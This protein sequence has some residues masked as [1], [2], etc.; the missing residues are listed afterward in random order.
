MT[1]LR[2]G[3]LP[4][5]V[6]LLAACGT[7]EIMEQTVLPTTSVTI[8]TDS[9]ELFMEHPALVVDEAARF[10]VHLTD[11]TDFRPLETGRVTL[12]LLPR[13]PGEPLEVVQDGPRAPGIFGH[14]VTPTRAG[15]YDLLLLVDS[16]QARDSIRV[17]DVPVYATV[18][19]VPAEPEEASADISFLKEQQWK[20]PGFRTAPVVAGRMVASFDASGELIPAAGRVADVVAPVAAFLEPAGLAR[21]PT[22]GARV[23]LGQVLVL[24]TPA[25]EGGGSTY[26]EA[27]ARLREA[28]DEHARAGRLFAAEAV[29]RRRLHEAEIRLAA[30]R[31][32][33]AAFGGGELQDG[34]L[35]VRAPIA[36]VVSA[37]AVEPGARLAAGD[38]LF[39]I[40]DPS[41]LWLAARVPASRIGAVSTAAAEFA[42][43]GES[44]VHRT[45]RRAAVSPTVDPVSRT[46]TVLYEVANPGAALRIGATARVM[47]RTGEQVEGLVIPATAVLEEDGRP[48]AFVQ[49]AGET[50]QR[51]DLRVAARDAG[52]VLVTGGLREGERVVSGEPYQVRLASLS[53]AVPAHGHE[54]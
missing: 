15:R 34:R 20:T 47:V 30:A 35:P 50:F 22:L 32:A 53:T 19:E 1:P 49:L 43:D 48:I 46:V 3:A 11:H 39:T 13:G 17:P 18:E 25:L 33:L 52:L 38:P 26:A 21:A 40:V 2:R 8:W 4:A 16:P 7:A 27:R 54:H 42:L 5:A 24:L 29:P 36:G 37:R 51:R 23:A 28:E 12:R 10:A 41:T 45:G 9:T 6:G 44:V 14:T 31:E